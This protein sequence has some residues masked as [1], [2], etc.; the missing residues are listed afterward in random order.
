M[1]GRRAGLVLTGAAVI[2][3]VLRSDAAAAR[4]EV[5]GARRVQ[6]VR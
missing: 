1:H 4:A 3:F 5:N 2:G 6:R